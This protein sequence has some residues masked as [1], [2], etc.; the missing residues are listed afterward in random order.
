MRILI[1]VFFLVLSGCIAGPE[2]C[3]YDIFNV[4]SRVKSID[5]LSDEEGNKQPFKV[6]LE[7]TGSP[8]A[9]RDH[10]L[11]EI[12]GTPI[13]LEFLKNNQ[14]IVGMKWNTTVSIRKSGDCTPQLI[15]IQ[16]KFR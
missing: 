12:I 14:L 6:M 15:T 2:Q 11:E 1:P 13:D 3:D 9:D 10:N 8:L 5:P 4:K 16:R 7:L